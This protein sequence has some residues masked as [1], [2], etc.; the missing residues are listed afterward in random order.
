M[1]GQHGWGG[2]VGLACILWLAQPAANAQEG[3]TEQRDFAILV[4]GKEAGQSH[5]TI[6]VQKDG[7]TVVAASAQVKVSQVLFNYT[8][9]VESTEWW[10]ADK[11]TGLKAATVENGKRTEVAVTADGNWLRLKIN[12]QERLRA[13]EVWTSSFWKLADAK[14]HNKAVP[15]LEPD[16]GK[17][18]NGHLRYVGTEQLTYLNQPQSCYHFQV[19][20]GSY[21]VDVWF[22]RYHRLVRQEFTDLG[23]K[24]IIQLT[25]LKR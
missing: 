18:F 21:P 8:Y 19:T 5:M 16:S 11:L 22:D 24:T 15:I 10:K 3:D 7:T 14:Y 4:D 6:T 17:E 9:K 12:G 13:L 2:V 1:A 23:H 20:G 25:A